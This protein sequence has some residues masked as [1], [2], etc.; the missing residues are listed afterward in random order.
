[1]MFL[2]SFT[3]ITLF[4]TNTLWGQN[5]TGL[6]GI[7]NIAI[8][9]SCYFVSFLVVYVIYLR[10]DIPFNLFPW[11]L[12]LFFIACGT[13][14]VIYLENLWHP[15]YWLWGYAE[16]V[17]AILALVSAVGIF[18]F[19]P[20]VINF[21]SSQQLKEINERLNQEIAQFQSLDHKIRSLNAQL[22]KK[23]DERTAELK[24]VNQKL[25]IEVE[26]RKQIASALHRQ[27]QLEQLISYFSHRFINVTPTELDFTINEALSSIKDFVAIDRS[28]LFLFTKEDSK[29]QVAQKWSVPEFSDSFDWDRDMEAKIPWIMTNI[30][31]NIIVSLPEIDS[32]P[33]EAERDRLYLAT[34][35]IKSLLIV[36]MSCGS[37]MKGILALE[38]VNHPNFWTERDRQ[39]L[40][41]TG[42][43][44][45]GAVERCRQAAELAHRTEQL[46]TS[47]QELE[48][49]AYIVSHDLS[50]PLRSISGFSYLLREEYQTKL[51]RE[52]QEYLD[53]IN[54]GALRMKALIQDLLAFSRV[55]SQN[56]V[57]TPID[58]EEVIKEVIS[59]LQ[60]AIIENNV[61]I[62]WETLPNIV[63]DR[64]KFV[65]LWQNLIANAIKFQNS[66]STP[67][68]HISVTQESQKLIFAIQD[69]G[70]GIDRKYTREIF[71]V[72]RRLHNR[73]KYPGTGIGLAICRR[74]AELHGGK[75]WVESTLGQGSTFYILLPKGQ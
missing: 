59:N 2:K 9:I 45:S 51:D 63:A 32:L 42:E 19:I 23:I 6:H 26:E 18:C 31:S 52:A 50:E 25:T 53:F 7:S 57:L 68:I 55:G 40:K 48:K 73:E 71:S 13:I 12:V 5:V 62:E 22:E 60:A 37:T 36:P 47:N 56:L 15:D 17:T 16:S 75:I 8:A 43:I 69:N 29:L 1:M 20:Q 58:L 65:Q 49:F 66:E 44:I 41:L 24:Q 27:I 39:L 11:F 4:T 28:Y 61:Q 38:A 64:T 10:K 67:H 72:F 46:E 70:I 21:P 35:K 33:L 74:I 54:D 34:H 14:N 30:E 3:L